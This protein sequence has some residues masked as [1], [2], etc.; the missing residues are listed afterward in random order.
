MAIV[1]IW[2]FPKIRA[3]CFGVVIIRIL[4]FRGTIIRVPCFGVVIIDPT[5]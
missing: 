2:D 5:I 4:L 1:V 3:P